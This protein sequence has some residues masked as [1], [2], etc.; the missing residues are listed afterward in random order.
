MPEPL[1]MPPVTQE[2]SAA[3]ALMV[4]AVVTALAV[5]KT[6]MIVTALAVVTAFGVGKALVVVHVAVTPVAANPIKALEVVREVIHVGRQIWYA[7]AAI[8]TVPPKRAHESV[9]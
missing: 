7:T 8:V 9:R 6:L 5:V 1:A 2:S 4:L 3:I